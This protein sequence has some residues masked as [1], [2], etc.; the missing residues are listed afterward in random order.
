MLTIIIVCHVIVD[1][2]TYEL[3]LI[4]LDWNMTCF[5]C[6]SVF[7][8]IVYFVGIVENESKVID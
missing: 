7:D 1:Y 8:R 6:V 2:V 3:D 4:S 5:I